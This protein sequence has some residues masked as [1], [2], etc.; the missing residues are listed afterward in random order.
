MNSAP[1]AAR[2]H[3]AGVHLVGRE[4]AAFRARPR[5]LSH[6]R[7][8]VGVDGVGAGDGLLRV[9]EQAQPRAVA[10]D[11]RGLLGHAR[12]QLVAVRRGHVHGDAE[13][14]A[15]VRERG[16]HVVAVAHERERPPA[17]APP[18][19]LQ[20]QD[21][22]QR[23]AGVLFVGQRVDDV[24]PGRRAA[25]STRICCAKVRMTAALT[26]RSRLRATS[27]IGSRPPSATSP[28]RATTSPPSLADRNLEG[29][30]RAQRRLL[31]Q[32]RHVGPRERVRGRRLR[33]SARSRFRRPASAR[34]RSSSSG[35]K[36]STERKLLAPPAGRASGV[37]GRVMPN[38]PPGAPSSASGPVVRV[39]LHVLRAQVA[40]PHRGLVRRRPSRGR[41]RSGYPLPAGTRRRW[42]PPR[43]TAR[44]PRRAPFARS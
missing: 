23:L 34:Q 14:D 2:R 13:H 21:V 17:P 28:G 30:P 7:P 1:G 12:G 3:Q 41:P 31:E 8:D 5:L 29:Q 36:S 11:A 27:T 33:P 6:R 32:H 37:S 10:R 20:R 35:V 19:L 43:R 24:E 22:G 44:P 9:T 42:A 26:Q 18:V 25:N 15:R 38:P 40:R 4:H 39:D 16:R